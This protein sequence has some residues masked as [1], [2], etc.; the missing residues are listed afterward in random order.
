MGCRAQG[1]Q[2]TTQDT[3]YWHTSQ[4]KQNT[5]HIH[6]AYKLDIKWQMHSAEHTILG[7]QSQVHRV[8]HIEPSK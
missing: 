1:T 6:Q 7:I 3:Q 2:H 8:R 5:E 4:E